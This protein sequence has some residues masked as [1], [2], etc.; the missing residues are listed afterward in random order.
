MSSK[1]KII[2][3]YFLFYL[4]SIYFSIISSYRLYKNLFKILKNFKFEKFSHI[5]NKSWDLQYWYRRVF[6]IRKNFNRH[7][8][9][10]KPFYEEESNKL[11]YFNTAL[12]L[13]SNYNLFFLS[14]GFFLILSQIIFFSYQF[15]NIY[16]GIL[17]VILVL[18][19][20]SIIDQFK[21]QNYNLLY[22]IFL[23]TSFFFL[24]QNLYFYSSFLI[25]GIPGLVGISAL[26]VSFVFNFIF[27]IFTRFDINYLLGFSGYLLI[28][29][30]FLKKIFNEHNIKFLFIFWLQNSKEKINYSR[31]RYNLA[32][33]LVFC[34]YFPFI[35]CS[36]FL[37]ENFFLILPVSVLILIQIL[38]IRLFDEQLIDLIYLISSL[39]I[40]ISVEFN[41]ILFLSYL[42]S[43]LKPSYD[44]FDHKNKKF[45]FFH[46]DIQYI[47]TIKILNSFEK[48]I[49]GIKKEKVM[50]FNYHPKSEY[51]SHFGRQKRWISLF[52]FINAKNRIE[53]MPTWDH[54][55]ALKSVSAKKK[56]DTLWSSTF[57]EFIKSSN[58]NGARY[59]L[60]QENGLNEKKI[61]KTLKKK[62]ILIGIINIKKLKIKLNREISKGNF[63]LFDKNKK[64]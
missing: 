60:I 16:I 23:P 8:K 53:I 44:L 4:F 46:N 40:I 6:F 7:D 9:Y 20:H 13:Y 55:F 33:L 25:S 63:Y 61:I 35:I 1:K 31:K 32:S 59:L 62:F 54:V 21:C 38:F 57:K 42:I 22:Y 41:I 26:F 5:S 45:N 10:E 36:F 2:K 47:N 24:E 51:Y 48:I 29:P 17:S 58:Y 14:T 12:G 37:T 64:K 18:F 19:S 56:Y 28:L 3:S 34:S 39:F 30:V 43:I 11:N 52:Q 49:T 15:N 27:L 50:F